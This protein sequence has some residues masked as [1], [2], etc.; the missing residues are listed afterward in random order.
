MPGTCKQHA[1]DHLRRG[2]QQ[3]SDQEYGPCVVFRGPRGDPEDAKVHPRKRGAHQQQT[4]QRHRRPQALQGV[5][6]WIEI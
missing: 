2:G 6:M 4:H 3:R 5:R 1:A